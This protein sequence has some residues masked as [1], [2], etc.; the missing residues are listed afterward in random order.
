MYMHMHRNFSVAILS[1]HQEGVQNT[2]EEESLF[3]NLCHVRVRTYIASHKI[4]EFV[5]ILLN[6]VTALWVITKKENKNKKYEFSFCILS[7]SLFFQFAI[8]NNLCDEVTKQVDFIII[9]ALLLA[10][11]SLI[12]AIHHWNEYIYI[13]FFFHVYMVWKCF[14]KS[15]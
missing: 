4:Y 10:L 1:N 5:S 12:C 15:E 13:Y 6:Q 3:C 7:H 2:W 8:S 14:E 9:C 11:Y